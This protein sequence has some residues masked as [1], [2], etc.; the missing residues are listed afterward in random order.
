M[1]V[2]LRGLDKL[3]T[4][5]QRGMRAAPHLA[6]AV[7]AEATLVL[8]EAKVLVPVDTGALRASGMVEPPKIED[9]KVTV[10]VGFGGAAAG[11]ALYVHEDPNASHAPGKSFKYLEIPAMAHA[12]TFSQNVRKRLEAYI[13]GTA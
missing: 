9:Q 11:Y 13:R 4:Q 12:P 8:N 3:L 2:T 5:Y 7:F 1:R 10:T 6:Q